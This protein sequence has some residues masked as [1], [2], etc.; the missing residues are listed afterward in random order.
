V[1]D[2][3]LRGINALPA[4]WA[5]K[6]S[7]KLLLSALADDEPA[8]RR[9][10]LTLASTKVGFLGRPDALEYLK[11]LLVD[12]DAKVRTL[13]LATVEQ[14]GLIEPSLARRVKA[15]AA[16]PA[17]KDRALA[18]LTAHHLDPATIEPDVPLSRPRLLSFSTFRRTVNPLFYQPGADKY[19]CASCHANHTILRIAEGDPAHG[20]PADQL[21]VNFNSALKVVNLGDP[22]ASLIL[23]KPRSPH[24]QGGAEPSSPTGL[25]HVGG[26]RWETTEHP[27]Y[28]AILQWIREASASA[29]AEA[30]AE[31]LSADSYAPNFEPSL[32]GDGDQSTLWHTEFVGAMPGYPH[33]L[34]VDL[35]SLRIAEGL[36]YVPRQDSPNGRVKDFEIHISTDGKTWS[37]P[38]AKGRWT[39]DPSFKYVALPGKVAR[40]VRLR[41]LSEVEGRPFMTAAELSV[42]TS[43]PIDTRER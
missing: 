18:V 10:G 16:D 35:G 22:E 2:R 34:V 42:D 29:R 17:L 8:L 4:L 5:G 14:Q 37:E 15:V 28:R 27:A 43:S 19:A 38:I 21:M 23:R 6:G 13:A 26:P 40:Y 7:N 33:E 1:R 36:V 32:A 39:N 3:A 30:P 20:F 9:R 24:G 41:G 25:S 12:P 11:R 31:K